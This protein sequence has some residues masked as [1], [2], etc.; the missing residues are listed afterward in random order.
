M[1][2]RLVIVTLLLVT[3]AAIA[4]PA[5]KPI[6]Q[7]RRSASGYSLLVDGKPFLMLGAQ[8]DNITSVPEQMA[9]ALPGFR[10]YNANTVEFPVSW[11]QIEPQQGHYDFAGTD[12]V[13]RDIR[14]RG[15]RAVVLWFGTWKGEET[16]FLPDW[17][18]A[19]RRRF[20]T[21]LDGRGRAT[22]SL[23]PFGQTTL[24][25]DRR[26]FVAL[27]QNLRDIDQHD[28]TVI[29]VQVENEPGIMG[30][31]RD[32]SAQAQRLFDAPI[33]APLA[34][35]LKRNAD[36]W[37]QSFGRDFADE[38]FTSYYIARYINAVAEAGKAVYPLPMLVNVWLGGEG[39]SILFSRFDRPGEGYPSGGGQ[40]RTLDV[41]KAA[42]PAIDLLA[43]DIYNRSA[44]Q[45]RAILSS[46]A[47]AD[48]PL[49]LVETGRGME[50][51]RYAFMAIGQFGALGIA[52]FGAGIPMFGAT[53][54]GEFGPGFADMAA[55]YRLLANAAPLILERRGTRMLQAA[56]EE[57]N[58]YG[59]GLSF[60]RWDAQAIFPP[61]LSTRPV[62]ADLVGPPRMP[63]G[64]V[65]IVQLQADEFLILGF[66]TRIVFRPPA[67]SGHEE[68]RLLQVEQGQYQQG[69]WSANRSLPLTAAALGVD[70]PAAGAMLRVKLSWN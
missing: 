10:A 66:D 60:E 62:W 53:A 21:A 17:I 51:A 27:M 24:A 54:D 46:Y 25:A 59:R 9:K 29:L 14:A 8:V 42:A 55:D 23:S 18:K 43:P 50:F 44:F 13:I 69:V 40:S 34:A 56:I 58:I 26:A 28:R 1:L 16:Q 65:L 3:R 39:T 68:G 37:T 15:L 30:T 61:A 49:L 5:D 48:N 19:D 7:L 4:Q 52:Q 38:A 33:P 47:R 64:R 11:K 67:W 12:Q 32:H 6:A 63:S 22:A 45:Y 20:P 70:L 57:E 41:W 36:S 31:A 35:A 2:R